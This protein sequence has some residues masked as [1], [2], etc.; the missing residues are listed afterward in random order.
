MVRLE[1]A[2]EL[3]LSL[4]DSFVDSVLSGCREPSV[5]LNFRRTVMNPTETFPYRVELTV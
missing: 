1:D 3:I 5:L 2:E 4:V